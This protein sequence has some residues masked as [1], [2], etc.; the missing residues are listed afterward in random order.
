VNDFDSDLPARIK[1]LP[2]LT[3]SVPGIS[4]TGCY[5]FERFVASQFL[6]EVVP[7]HCLA[8]LRFL[9]FVF[10]PYLYDHWP[11]PEDPA[12]QDWCLTVDWLRDKINARGLTVSFVAE[13]VDP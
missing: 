9:E 11:Q 10:P 3:P 4:S 5:P 7:A 2:G 8:H 6:R 13:N 1:A 12:M